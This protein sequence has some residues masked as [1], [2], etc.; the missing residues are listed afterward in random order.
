M[1]LFRGPRVHVRAHKRGGSDVKAHER[2]APGK[3]GSSAASAAVAFTLALSGVAG[4]MSVEG[5]TSGLG[6]YGGTR[7]PSRS[8]PEA[9]PSGITDSLRVTTRLEKLGDQVVRVHAQHDVGNCADNSDG[10]VQRFF[11]EVSECISLDREVIEVQEKANTFLL[12]MAT[13]VMPTHDTAFHL[14]LLLDQGVNGTI[15]PLVPDRGK[16]RNLHWGTT[17]ATT[18]LNNTTVT[19][20]DVKIVGRTLV[21]SV[22]DSFLNKGLSGLR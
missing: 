7:P 1:P 20:Y 3:S 17:R 5:G 6:D 11:R 16:Y 19:L 22:A 2:S 4:G 8:E 13:I 18:S 14:R 21:A 15:A 12:A 9:G 10:D